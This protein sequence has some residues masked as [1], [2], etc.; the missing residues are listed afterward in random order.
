MSIAHQQLGTLS[1]GSIVL[2]LP[3]VTL[4]PPVIQVD[5]LRL[6]RMTSCFDCP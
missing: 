6:P 3:E 1:P 4:L 5:S 2:L